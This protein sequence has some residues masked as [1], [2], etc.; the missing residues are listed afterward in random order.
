MTLYIPYT[1]LQDI[2]KAKTGKDVLLRTIN[3]KTVSFVYDLNMKLPVIG[4]VSKTVWLN[5]TVDK[6][7][8]EE[9][10]LTY[11][12]GRGGDVLIKALQKV[13]P[14][15]KYSSYVD[16]L[17]NKKIIVHLYRVEEI[18][19]ALQQLKVDSLIFKEDKV[20]LMFKV[21]V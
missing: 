3:E 17:D 5:V 15:A 19:K 10:H 8:D 14:S 4:T 12:A 16:F 20:V 7:V 1:E 13:I 6:L 21:K 11:E 9:L 2:L 18:H